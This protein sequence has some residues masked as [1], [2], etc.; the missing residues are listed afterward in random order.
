MNEAPVDVALHR[1]RRP[2]IVHMRI[3]TENIARRRIAERLGIRR[4][5]DH[6]RC[7]SQRRERFVPTPYQITPCQFI[8]EFILELPTKGSITASHRWG[9]SGA[10]TKSSLS[11]ASLWRLLRS[12]SE[13]HAARHRL[14]EITRR[15]RQIRRGRE[16]SARRCGRERPSARRLDKSRKKKEVR[17]TEGSS[18]SS[19][20]GFSARARTSSGIEKPSSVDDRAVASPAAARLPTD[21]TTAEKADVTRLQ[22]RDQQVRQEEK[23]HAAVAGD[24][25]GPISYVFQRGPD[26]RQYAVGG[27]VGI[28]AS[29][30]SGDPAEA[31][32]KAGRMAAAANAAT[33]PFSAG[34]RRRT[35]S[36]CTRQP[37]RPA[38]SRARRGERCSPDTVIQSPGGWSAG[39]VYRRYSPD[40]PRQIL[41]SGRS[42]NINYGQPSML[43]LAGF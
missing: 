34:L 9:R 43:V 2:L 31:A 39:S 11:H 13:H 29:V 28:Q 37:A 23:A 19:S 3:E 35:T 15:P 21:L 17:G 42:S 40:K 7:P 33:Q 22:Q 16:R 14:D 6:G 8:V 20:G 18:V 30:S 27:S 1:I 41:N 4:T 5:T 24:L 25:A 12:E 32:R 38:V 36:L 10:L 26:G